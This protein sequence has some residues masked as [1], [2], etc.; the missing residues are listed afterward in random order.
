MGRFIEFVGMLIAAIILVSFFKIPIVILA[1]FISPW[2]LLGIF[3][4]GLI[5]GAVFLRRKFEEK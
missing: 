4:A 2:I 1:V 3:V 5:G